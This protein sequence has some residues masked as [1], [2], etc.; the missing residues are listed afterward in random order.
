MF[1]AIP[2]AAYG[3]I[4]RRSCAQAASRYYDTLYVRQGGTIDAGTYG[5]YNLIYRQAA[6]RA[7]HPHFY[8]AM[9]YHAVEIL[10]H[11]LNGLTSLSQ[12]Q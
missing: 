1:R 9:F 11:C 4:S 5:G 6:Q 8:T 12:Q 2:A 7:C 10:R 3:P